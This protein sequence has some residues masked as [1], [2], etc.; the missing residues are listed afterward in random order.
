MSS[1]A[2][3]WYVAHCQRLK[4]RR[5]AAALAEQ[6]DLMVYLPELRR[7][8]AGHLQRAPFFPGYLFVQADLRQ[9]VPSRINAVPGVLRLVAFGELPLPVPA[10]VVE[11]IRQR[12]DQLNAQGGLIVP[13]LEPGQTL[14][15]KGGM[16]QGLEAVFLGPL[17]PSE[18]VQVL[19][20]FLGSLRRLELPVDRVEPIGD[21]PTPRRE[22]RTR[23][24]GR[25][26]QRNV[27]AES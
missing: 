23:G 8:Q 25:P 2:S 18:R 10:P 5:A 6:L 17:K 11:G 15:L 4:E 21:Q 7:R 27:K 19:I 20:E 9:V 22:R 24:R 16:F 13:R 26:I 12:V 3:Q 1:E 14:R